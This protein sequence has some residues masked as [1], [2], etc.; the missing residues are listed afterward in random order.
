MINEQMGTHIWK[1][2]NSFLAIWR[3][4]C[5]NLVRTAGVAASAGDESIECLRVC[6]VCVTSGE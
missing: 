4:K 2:K 3:G 6:Y 5:C 1:M